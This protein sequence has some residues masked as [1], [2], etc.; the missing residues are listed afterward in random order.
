MNRH[1]KMEQLLFLLLF[2]FKVKLQGSKVKRSGH[3]T[4]AINVF[5]YICISLILIVYALTPSIYPLGTVKY[6]EI[7]WK[8]MES[9]FKY[10][11]NKQLDFDRKK[12]EVGKCK[13]NRSNNGKKE[14]RPLAC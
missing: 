7:P 8:A 14:N 10:L 4:N 12:N 6:E 1:F 9:V 2:P 5:A 3:I 13:E 11:Q